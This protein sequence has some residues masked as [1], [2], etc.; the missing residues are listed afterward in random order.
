MEINNQP[1]LLPVEV[2]PKKPF[3]IGCGR[4]GMT[5]D[6]EIFALPVKRNNPAHNEAGGND[7][8]ACRD[9]SDLAGRLREV[10]TD[11]GQDIWMNDSSHRASV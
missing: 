5:S 11:G 6:L 8:A 7:N 3:N 4:Q 2:Q 1:P 9:A 10:I